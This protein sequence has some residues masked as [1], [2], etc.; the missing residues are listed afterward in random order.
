MRRLIF[1]LAMLFVIS[2][3]DAVAEI[4]GRA[5]VI[6]GDTIEIGGQRA[7]K[8]RKVAGARSTSQQ[9][10]MDGNGRAAAMWE[11]TL[12]WNPIRDDLVIGSYRR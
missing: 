9:T 4:A 12:N 11:W 3:H 10:S 2:A 1:L 7:C 8:E 6:N 5:S